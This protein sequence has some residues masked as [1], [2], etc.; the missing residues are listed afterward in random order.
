MAAMFFDGSKF[1][2][3]IFEKGYTSNNL[4]T[5]FQTLTSGFREEDF[6]RISSRPYS[7]RTL[8]PPHA[9]PFFLDGSE[10]CKQFLKSEQPCE[11][12]SKSDKWFQR[13]RFLKNSL[14]N[15]IWL[16]W[17]PEFLMESNSAN[18]LKRGPPKKYSCQVWF[19]L[20]LRFRRS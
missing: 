8:P 17:Q 5:L 15:S 12:I 19:K 11:I 20:A 13:R 9:G 6:L 10:F 2:E 16:P 3:N 4:V 7:A 1:H 14:K 18:N